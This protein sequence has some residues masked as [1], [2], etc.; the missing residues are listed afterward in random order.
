MSYTI[1]FK[2]PATLVNKSSIVEDHPVYQSPIALSTT[3]KQMFQAESIANPASHPVEKYSYDPRS[4]EFKVDR[5]SKSDSVLITNNDLVFQLVEFHFHQPAE[6][7]IDGERGDIELH[8]VFKSR[9]NKEA[10][11]VI[12][13]IGKIDKT[14][15]KS[16]KIF[17]RIISGKPFTVPNL[18]GKEYFSYTGS[19]TAEPFDD[20]IGWNVMRKFLRITKFDLAL[21]AGKSKDA[22]PLQPRD[23]RDIVLASPKIVRGVK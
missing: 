19:L 13:V 15:D 2:T 16:S 8:F 20:A 23:G 4:K 12:A 6:H 22:R 21:L 7:V 14:K 3:S 1:K 9:E 10:S 5:G 18:V 11:Y 17:R